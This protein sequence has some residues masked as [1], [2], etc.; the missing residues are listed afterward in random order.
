MLDG[1]F[2]VLFRFRQALPLDKELRYELGKFYTWVHGGR[3]D[4]LLEYYFERFNA[5]TDG[6]FKF[7]KTDDI[8]LTF[9]KAKL[10]LTE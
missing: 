3:Y 2:L 4:P 10:M 1:A 7:T 5:S 8:K 9:L 6:K